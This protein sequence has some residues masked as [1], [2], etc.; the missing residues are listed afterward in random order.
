M[1]IKQSNKIADGQWVVAYTIPMD[2]GC[3]FNRHQIVV[4]SK[5]KPTIKQLENAIKNRDKGAGV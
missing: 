3:G 5:N 1:E 4:K 2:C